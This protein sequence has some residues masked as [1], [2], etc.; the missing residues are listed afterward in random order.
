MY[1]YIYIYTYIHI[2][3]Y[4]CVCIIYNSIYTVQISPQI[5]TIIFT[6]VHQKQLLKNTTVIIVV[7][8]NMSS[9]KMLLNLLNTSGS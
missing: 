2:Y 9:A 8:L 1:T 4:V 3:I 5:T 6:K 7:T